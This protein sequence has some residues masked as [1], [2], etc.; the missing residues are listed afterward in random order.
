MGK[1]D[2]ALAATLVKIIQLLILGHRQPGYYTYNIVLDFQVVRGRRPSRGDSFTNVHRA[3]LTEV[4]RIL[5]ANRGFKS[6]ET[7]AAQRRRRGEQVFFQSRRNGGVS[8]AL[9]V[10]PA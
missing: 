1:S 8:V 3:H 10:P 5:V 6:I 4:H 9:E 7:V 2:C